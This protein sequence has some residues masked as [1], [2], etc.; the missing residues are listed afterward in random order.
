MNALN[1]LRGQAVALDLLDDSCF[2]R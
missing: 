2:A 1:T